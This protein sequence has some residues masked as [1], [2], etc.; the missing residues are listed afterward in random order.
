MNT[1]SITYVL[2]WELKT[3]LNYKWSEC[4]KCFN[5]KTGMQIKQVVNGRSI[6]YCINGKFQSLSTLRK[7]MQ[8]IKKKDCPF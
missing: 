1:I 4:G 8:L 3:S 2:K 6:G 7:E 5:S